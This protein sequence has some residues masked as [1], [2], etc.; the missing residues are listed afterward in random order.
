MS[1]VEEEK[2]K[3]VQSRKGG[4]NRQQRERRGE[5]RRREEKGNEIVEIL[6]DTFIEVVIIMLVLVSF[7]VFLGLRKKRTDRSLIH[8][9][10]KPL[11][12]IMLDPEDVEG[13]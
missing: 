4:D 2:E 9:L 13:N 11:D 6:R 10:F 12:S 5:Q 7:G 1:D 3:R 8:P